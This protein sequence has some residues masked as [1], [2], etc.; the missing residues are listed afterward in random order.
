MKQVKH[1][2]IVDFVDC[3]KAGEFLYLVMEWA[4]RGDLY[5]A[6]LEQRQKGKYFAEKEL[7]GVAW[8]L[9]L[10]LLHLHSH[11]VIHRD[12]KCM[13]VLLFKG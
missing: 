10:A 1:H 12:V 13:N 6:I 4:E 8:Q 2:H 5:Q 3:F 9:C 7:W 11:D